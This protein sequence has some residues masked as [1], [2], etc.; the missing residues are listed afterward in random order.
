MKQI[1]STG[2][3]AG[4]TSAAVRAGDL[5]YLSGTTAESEGGTPVA[6][7]VGVQTTSVLERMRGLLEAA[8]SSLDGVVSVMVYLTSASDFGEMNDAYRAYWPS[9]PP[10]RTTV[11]TELVTPGALVEISMI[12]VPRGGER[13]VVHPDGWLPAQSPY[14]YGIR[15]GDT[16][17]LSGLVPRYGRDNSVIDGDIGAQTRAVM[18]NASELLEA[19]GMTFAN[20]VSSRVYLTQGAN[21]PSMNTAYKEFFDAA[22][23]TR[24]TVVAGLAAPPFLV[25]M[26]FTASSASREPVGTA[27]AGI[28]LSPA[29]R[30]GKRLYLSG[31]LG[32]TPESAGDVGAQT[33]ETL[34]RIGGT[35]EAAGAS[36]ADVVDAT[37]F[38]TSTSGYAAMNEPFG[39]VFGPEYP[40]RTTVVTPLVVGDGLV[41]IMVTAVLP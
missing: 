36:A 31:V 29:I 38:L 5:V 3:N 23:P 19:A 6:G 26:T 8:G 11:I 30:A 1:V 21:F 17:F 13:L 37:V 4:P 40:A 20:V 25:E 10:T 9:N 35:L 27:P 15:T 7:G 34:A 2:R 14:S 22:P 16:L 39:E 41:E 18:Q 32:N 12:A 28:P 33:R 24:A